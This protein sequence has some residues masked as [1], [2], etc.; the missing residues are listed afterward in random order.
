MNPIAP[1]LNISRHEFDTAI[2]RCF[3]AI[4]KFEQAKVHRFGLN[5]NAIFLLQFLR[6]QS[7]STMGILSQEMQ[8][9]VSTATR[10]VDRLVAKGLISR[11]KSPQDKRIV[12]VLLEPEG[13]RLVQAVE[14]HSFDVITKNLAHFTAAE[15]KAFFKTAVSMEKILEIPDSP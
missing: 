4:Y 6:R 12:L 1:P 10:V 15:I 14:N 9:P 7:P 11:K 13:K 3:H 2:V 8:I 5:Y